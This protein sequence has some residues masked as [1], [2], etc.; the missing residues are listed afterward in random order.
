MAQLRNID[1]PYAKSDKELLRALGARV[2]TLRLE[3]NLSQDQVAAA[4]G[5]GRATLV[6]LEGGQSVTL[7]SFVQVLRALEVLEELES[8]LPE[9]GVSPLQLLERQGKRRRRASP[10]H[11]GPGSGSDRGGP[12]W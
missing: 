6:R 12:A 1:D 8:F 11:S 10:G 4:A 7:L 9:P 5:V 3:R 2:K